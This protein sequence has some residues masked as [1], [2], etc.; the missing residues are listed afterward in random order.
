MR[1]KVIGAERIEAKEWFHKNREGIFRTS[2]K[3]GTETDSGIAWKALGG[4]AAFK[5]EELAIEEM[6]LGD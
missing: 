6:E 1:I 3:P 5:Q 4:F 2:V